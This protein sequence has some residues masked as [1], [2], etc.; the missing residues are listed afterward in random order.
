MRMG[1]T[2][3]VTEKEAETILSGT[4]EGHALTWKL[5]QQGRFRV[6]G[7]SYFPQRRS[8]SSNEWPVPAEVEYDFYDKELDRSGP[9]AP[10]GGAA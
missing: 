7:E 6:N 2:F 8:V 10:R 9:L 3:R 1:V 5:I 4:P